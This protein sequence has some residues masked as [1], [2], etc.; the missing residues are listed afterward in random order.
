MIDLEKENREL[1]EELVCTQRAARRAVEIADRNI[2][3]CQLLV[4][5][6]KELTRQRDQYRTQLSRANE[7]I[8][9]L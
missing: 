2:A 7:F 6:V 9:K 3:R 5:E 8:S 1:K 4:Q